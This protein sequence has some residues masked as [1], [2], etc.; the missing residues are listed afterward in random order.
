MERRDAKKQRLRGARFMSFGPFGPL[1]ALGERMG[2]GHPLD[3]FDPEAFQ[4]GAYGNVESAAEPDRHS[5][6][7][8]RS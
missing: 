3:G 4:N 8:R 2:Q 6:V 1:G 5:W 7:D